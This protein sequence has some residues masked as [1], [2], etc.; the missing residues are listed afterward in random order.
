MK[1]K[2]LPGREIREGK[3]REDIRLEVM[4]KLERGG[5]EDDAPESIKYPGWKAM[6]YVI[7]AK[8]TIHKNAYILVDR[9]LSAPFHFISFLIS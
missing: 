9:F 3:I 1:L 5:E 7:G 4:E 8:F 6:P 2:A